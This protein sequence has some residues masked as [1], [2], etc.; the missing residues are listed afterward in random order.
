M[1]PHVI[2]THTNYDQVKQEVN[3]H[4]NNC[5][6][7]RLLKTFDEDSRKKSN[8]RSR[9]TDVHGCRPEAMK[10]I[11]H[12]RIFDYVRGGVCR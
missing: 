3:D 4:E 2:Q 11:A 12:D 1:L 8:E 5:N 9:D 7:D 6:P 10:Q